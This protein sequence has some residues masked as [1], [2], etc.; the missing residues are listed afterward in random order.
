MFL[1]DGGVEATV[2]IQPKLEVHFE[3]QAPSHKQVLNGY[4]DY[5]NTCTFVFISSQARI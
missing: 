4:I 3:K 1:G 2:P 5:I